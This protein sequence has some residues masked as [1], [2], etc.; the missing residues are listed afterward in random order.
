MTIELVL[1]PMMSAL[2]LTALL[3]NRWGG[4]SRRRRGRFASKIGAH[5]LPTRLLALLF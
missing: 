1:A 5:F 4:G 2:A 3:A